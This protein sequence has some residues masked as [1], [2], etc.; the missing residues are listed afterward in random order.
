M[1]LDV[2]TEGSFAIR[3]YRESDF[4]GLV[5]L[6][7]EC[8]EPGIAYPPGEMTRFLSL[9]TREVLVADLNGKLAGFCIGYRAPRSLGRIV[10]LDVRAEH[11]RAGIG[12]ALLHRT[13]ERLVLA[14]ADQTVLEVDV[15]NAAAISF[16][17]R[18]GFERSAMLPDY[19]GPGLAGLEMR[20]TEN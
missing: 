17:E 6:D 18:L 4:S 15:R 5:A 3:D 8:F 10:T 12:R 20:K 14:G 16:Y 13:I 1:S 7:S 11:R 19:Y 9:A 2:R